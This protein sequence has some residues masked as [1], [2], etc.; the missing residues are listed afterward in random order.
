MDRSI[1]FWPTFTFPNRAS[2]IQT[3]APIDWAHM[4]AESLRHSLTIPDG[5]DPIIKDRIHPRV[6]PALASVARSQP[7]VSL[8]IARLV[9]PLGREDTLSS[10][11]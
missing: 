6:A 9:P 11:T 7:S 3:V 8:A 5:S 10:L 4:A 1:H 2:P